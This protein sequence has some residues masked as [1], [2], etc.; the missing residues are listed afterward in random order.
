MS[1][2]QASQQQGLGE[3]IVTDANVSPTGVSATG[4]IS[5]VLVWGR[6]VPNQN[7]SYTPIN[8]AQSASFAT[9]TP[10]QS[11]GYSMVA[12]SQTPGFAPDEPLQDPLW[13]SIAA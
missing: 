9:I 4:E 13:S 11:A 10:S 12:P 3:V 7:P 5:K 2:S 8:P 1:L 6:I